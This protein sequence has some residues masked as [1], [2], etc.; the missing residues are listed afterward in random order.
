MTA[1]AAASP[2]S[3]VSGPDANDIQP[4]AHLDVGR[5]SHADQAMH[6]TSDQ[7]AR[8]K[9]VDLLEAD[10]SQDDSVSAEANTIPILAVAVNE[11]EPAP[12]DNSGWG[13]AVSG[14][15]PHADIDGHQSPA[16]LPPD[17]TESENVPVSRSEVGVSAVVEVEGTSQVED[18][19]RIRPAK[20]DAD[21]GN[22][23]QQSVAPINKPRV[24]RKKGR[25]VY[26]ELDPQ[27][28]TVIAHHFRDMSSGRQLLQ[29]QFKVLMESIANDIS[30]ATIFHTNQPLT[31]LIQRR[32]F[33]V[34]LCLLS[35]W[36]V[37]LCV[38][39]VNQLSTLAVCHNVYY[40]FTNFE[41]R[42]GIGIS[43]PGI[44]RFG[45][46][47]DGCALGN[48]EEEHATV[49]GA[50]MIVDSHDGESRAMNGFVFVTSEGSTGLDAVKFAV[51]GSDDLEEWVLCGSS[52][53]HLPEVGGLYF[54]DH[55]YSTSMERGVAE[56]FDM[57][58][59]LFWALAHFV[60]PLALLLSVLLALVLS[61][62]GRPGLSV[63]CLHAGLC[64]A[65]II[66]LIASVL[67]FIHKGYKGWSAELYLMDGLGYLTFFLVLYGLERAVF[68]LSAVI[69]CWWVATRI[70]CDVFILEEPRHMYFA[71]L[72]RRRMLRRAAA[73]ME[74]DKRAYMDVWELIQEKEKEGLEELREV[75]SAAKRDG[76]LQSGE[77]GQFHRKQPPPR[78]RQSLAIFSWGGDKEEEPSATPGGG[79]AGMVDPSN[80][81][82]NLDQLYAQASACEP[83]FRRKVQQW[84][85]RSNGWFRTQGVEDCRSGSDGCNGCNGFIKWAEAVEQGM[86]DLVHWPELKAPERAMDKIIQSYGG[87]VP[88]IL[89]ICRQSIVFL[90]L[91]DLTTCL[92]LILADK[93]L[94][95]HTIKNR[96]DMTFDASASAMFRDLVVNL[97]HDDGS[98]R[99][100]AAETHVCEL[101][102]ILKGYAALQNA[103][104]HGRYIQFRQATSYSR[105]I[106]LWK[107]L[108]PRFL[109]H[110]AVEAVQE[111]TNLA[112][113]ISGRGMGGFKEPIYDLLGHLKG[114]TT[115]SEKRKQRMAGRRSSDPR[116]RGRVRSSGGSSD[117]EMSGV[118]S[119]PGPAAPSGPQDLEGGGFAS[120]QP[121]L[122][123][124]PPAAAPGSVL[125][126]GVLKN[127]ASRFNLGP[128]GAEAG[129]SPGA[130]VVSRGASKRELGSVATGNQ[131]A[132]E[133]LPGAGAR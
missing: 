129:L 49:S 8:T 88:R 29:R 76:L 5:G 64:T 85:L 72:M 119:L 101:Q 122:S 69:G 61:L 125:R 27:H 127:G 10:V 53:W 48:V 79:V 98:L 13:H 55:A 116:K 15:Q 22:I 115:A 42:R 132:P 63:G 24:R 62:R 123:P 107:S 82:T 50:S 16:L 6:P 128:P 99:R 3:G 133:P 93:S 1:M 34:A 23:S 97:R 108:V 126:K 73:E 14:A 114:H 37:G 40:R 112:R 94:K 68:E 104:T 131:V 12:Q 130:R 84:A 105:S 38:T 9:H 45:L 35:V 39:G 77:P 90:E 11:R 47:M 95:L 81:V 33:R 17:R 110:K 124:R 59:P 20:S 41:N 78:R 67:A 118:S 7:G 80:P 19:E 54:L 26:D 52:A 46:L 57:R 70:L 111:T 96:Y 58:A 71:M 25:K 43:D 28:Q 4:E 106:S 21:E 83:I 31:V 117:E 75:V 44:H 103:E 113:T 2:W 60:Q 102:L 86:E 100:V 32:Y 87:D 18:D 121:P 109:Q 56:H 65:G 51:E 89:D 74:S 66:C 30:G 120:S 91:A 36:F 92:E